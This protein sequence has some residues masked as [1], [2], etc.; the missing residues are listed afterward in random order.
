MKSIKKL[1]VVL[2]VIAI[3]TTFGT[4]IGQV[5][6]DPGTLGD[7][8]NNNISPLYDPGTLG[9]APTD[10]G[11]VPLFDPGTLG[12]TNETDVIPFKDPGTLG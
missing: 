11:T 10:T 2:S 9:S 1:A 12:V 5:N 3:L 4:G 6:K 8:G 7:T